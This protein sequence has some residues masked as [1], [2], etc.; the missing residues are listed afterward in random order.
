[1]TNKVPPNQPQQRTRRRRRAAEQPIRWADS[2]V[3]TMRKRAS[4][5]LVL[6]LVTA[7]VSACVSVQLRLVACRVVDEQPPSKAVYHEYGHD[8]VPHRS[9]SHVV[10]WIAAS[11]NLE[12]R[13]RAW[14]HLLW[15]SVGPRQDVRGDLWS[16]LVLRVGED[17]RSAL[18]ESV[19]PGESLYK[20]YI[21]MDYAT[22][23][24]H[25]ESMTF[26]TEEFLDLCRDGL[27]VR[28]GGGTMWG[29]RL[30]S[31]AAALPLRL[32]GTSLRLVRSEQP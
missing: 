26:E 18:Q 19:E 8:D 12:A 27:F 20:I 10:C 25:A 1:M 22:L 2:V 16:G 23:L 15:F 21:P 9:G 30:T 7:L 4:Q 29:A 13:A 6:A 11:T 31:N 24:R 17:E 28:F 5:C 14:T 3:R 32:D